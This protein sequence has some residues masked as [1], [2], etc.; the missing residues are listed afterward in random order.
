MRRIALLM[1]FLYGC[2]PPPPHQ[3]VPGGPLGEAGQTAQGPRQASDDEVRAMLA[4]SSLHQQDP[5]KP[6][7][8]NGLLTQI[9]QATT[10]RQKQRL[11]NHYH[12][13]ALLLPEAERNQAFQRLR[14]LGNP[15]TM[16]R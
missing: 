12:H 13:A 5:A 16:T 4:E 1:L 6:V 15:G 10:F 14:D 11:V 7:D 9:S 3:F 2:V 8:L